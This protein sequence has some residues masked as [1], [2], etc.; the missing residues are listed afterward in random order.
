[1]VAA[2][3]ETCEAASAEITALFERAQIPPELTAEIA[4]ARTALNSGQ[5]SVAVRS[6]ATAEDLP[7]A[8]FAGQQDT[9]LNVR[10][11][12][13]VLQAVKRCWASLWTGRAIAYRL[14]NDIDQ[15]SVALAVV[16]QQMV[17][18]E[19]SGVLFT[20]NP[21]NGRSDEILINAAWGLGEAVVGGLVTPD[22]L[23]VEKASGKVLAQH[24]ADKAVITVPAG[25]GT[26]LQPLTDGRRTARVLTAA[27]AAELAR[28]ARRIE[29]FYGAPQD[30]EWCLEAG[31]FYIVQARPITTLP[32]PELPAS[33]A[34]KLPEG[35]YA[36]MRNNI[37][38]LMAEPLSPLFA[39]LGLEAVNASLHRLLS[40]SFGMGGI[41]PAE[42]IVVVNRYAYFNGSISLKST[43][44]LVFGA[45]KILKK[46]FTGAVERWTQTGRPRYL[47]MVQAWQAQDWRSRSTAGLLESAQELTGAAID[48]Y[49]ALISGVIPA[50]WISEALFTAAYNR[51]VRRP[52][53]PPAPVYLLGYASLP[54]LA[55]QSLYSLGE[56]VRVQ[57]F[58][59]RYLEMTGTPQLLT[60]LDKN[61][62]ASGAIP[63]AAWQEFRQRFQKHLQIFGH[64]LYDLDFAHPVPAGDPTPVIDA[65]KLYLSGQG[66]NP[67]TRQQEAEKRRELAQQAAAS[68]LKGWRLRLFLK[69]L[70]AAQRYAPLRENG[71][72]DIGLAY[73]LIRQMLGE[74]GRRLAGAG[75]I[76]AAEDIYWLTGEQSFQAA[77]QVDAG[78]PAVPLQENVRL[79]K[80]E[81]QAALRAFPPMALP[82]MKVF[83]FDLMSLKGKGRRGGKGGVIKGVAASPGATTGTARVL[84]GPDDFSKMKPGDVLV[85]SITTPAWTPLFALASAVVTDV[86]GPLS[87]GSIV[88]REYGIPAVLGTGSATRRIQDGQTVTVD[89]SAGKVFLE[90]ISARE[91]LN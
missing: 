49:G 66:S 26:L 61:H 70:D 43:G 79:H 20:V 67:F 42:I 47:Q 63:E 15:N 14:K 37:V 89:G 6:S 80:A 4:A 53:D 21:V 40:A 3:P 23:T 5:K 36:A 12:E 86:G 11:M 64:M 9:F 25:T 58:L 17:D 24:V 2:R 91:S 32:E 82:Q 71:L 19:A 65:L 57:P 78:L 81:H 76:S 41:M 31:C 69:R 16:V 8:S 84:R 7:E 22:T 59:T 38:E 13:A 45:G 39:T 33:A 28:L 35:A 75:A 46:M 1:V 55:D 88:A 54:I 85:A 44:R 72:A 73:P 77:Q 34:W 52:T 68:R 62:P 48:A 56:W 30:I 27:Q 50:A 87:H 29:S 83:G 51:L 90:A 10:G 18:A 74:A 60:D